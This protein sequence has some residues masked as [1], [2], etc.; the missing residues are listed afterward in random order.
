MRPGAGAGPG[1]ASC[2]TPPRD[3]AGPEVTLGRSSHRVPLKHQESGQGPVKSGFGDRPKPPGSLGI[4]AKASDDRGTQDLKPPSPSQRLTRRVGSPGPSQD[5][6]RRGHSK[7]PEPSHHG[8]RRPLEAPT[9]A[10][11]TRPTRHSPPGTRGAAGAAASL[12]F[13]YKLLF[14]VLRWSCIWGCFSTFQ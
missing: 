13:G 9:G 14:S 3:L 10:L 12:C 7:R 1:S 11:G 6:G 4:R 5:A 8:D 2:P